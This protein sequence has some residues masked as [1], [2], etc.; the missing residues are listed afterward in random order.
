MKKQSIYVFLVLVLLLAG[1][2]GKE[3][4]DSA[5]SSESLQ[6]PPAY[7]EGYVENPQVTADQQLREIGQKVRD[8]KGELTLDAA[9]LD[10]ETLEIGDMKLTVWEVKNFHYIPTYGLIDFYHSY[11]HETEFNVVKLFVEIENTSDKALHF[12]P[13]ALLETSAGETKLW[14]D[15]I[16]L[17]ELNGLIAGGKSKKGSIGFI[18]EKSEFDSLVITTSDLFDENGEIVSPAQ[19]IQVNF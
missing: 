2:S 7:Y 9:S 4:T 12:A 17:E 1:C 16:Y 13:V 19:E 14:E 10:S 3:S 11:T 15:D 18:V 6:E 5:V 8:N